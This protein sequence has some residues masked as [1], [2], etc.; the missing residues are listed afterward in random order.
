MICLA[1]LAPVFILHYCAGP[2]IA[3]GDIVRYMALA[4][5]SGLFILKII[6]YVR[7]MRTDGTKDVRE[8]FGFKR[9]NT[10][11]ELRQWEAE[12]G[13]AEDPLAHLSADTRK[14]IELLMDAYV[15]DTSAKTTLALAQAYESCGQGQIAQLYYCQLLTN[16]KKSKEA[17]EIQNTNK[18]TAMTKS[19]VEHESNLRAIRP[20]YR[21]L[22]LLVI[23][24]GVIYF[25][26]FNKS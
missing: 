16:F 23:L 13:E 9:N 11:A 1:L 21:W 10:E 22:A 5:L 19:I 15:K 7:D 12:A 8:I 26:Y 14:K 20:F 24:L 4:G 2:G 3:N 18:I 17:R 25:L 6:I